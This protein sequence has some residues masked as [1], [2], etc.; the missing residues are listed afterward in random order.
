MAAVADSYVD[1]STVGWRAA[2]EVPGVYRERR[3]VGVVND[4]ERNLLGLSLSSHVI[5]IVAPVIARPDSPH[6]AELTWR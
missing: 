3:L 4:L 1:G 2:R 5:V 6:S